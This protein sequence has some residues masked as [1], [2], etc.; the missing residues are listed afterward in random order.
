MEFFYRIEP[1]PAE[2]MDRMKRRIVRARRAGMTAAVT[3][4]EALAVKK[5]PAR[6]SNLVNARTTE[7]APDGLK[8]VI[9]FTAR[10]AE[11]VHEGTGLHGPHKTR[12][13][14]KSKKALYWPGAAHPWKSVRGMTARPFLAD[15]AAEADMAKLYRDGMEDYLSGGAQ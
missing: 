3:G 11:Y 8:G 12:I 9:R 15:A 6:T 2:F 10:Y 5:A 13:I 7:V 4:I 1:K 14:P